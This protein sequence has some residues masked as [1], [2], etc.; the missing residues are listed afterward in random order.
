MTSNRF[1]QKC[2]L[3]P[4]LVL[5]CC[6]MAGLPA[7]QAGPEGAQNKVVTLAYQF[8][9]GRTV[10]YRTTSTQIQNLDAMGQSITTRTVNNMEF[11]AKSKGLKDDNFILGVTMDAF[12]VSVEGPQG[13][14][15]PDP[16]TV[17]G[18]SFDMI[19][20]RLGKVV[21]AAGASSISY[22]MGQSGKR[23]IAAG[24]QTFFPDLPDHPVKIGDAWTS[25]SAVVNRGDISEI[26]I[27]LKNEHKLDGFETAEGYECARIKTTAKGS[28][29]GTIEQSGMTMTLDGTVQ[30]TQTCYFAIKEGIF[31]KGDEKTGSA[32]NITVSAANMSIPIT[33]ESQGEVRLIRK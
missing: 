15:A 7:Q 22:D 19:I 33:S 3:I 12:K 13:N 23:N 2:L 1:V 29:R 6:G 14:T 9:E 10:A 16:S 32:G 30:S 27:A 21:D 5:A 17:I 20:S 26:R 4:M 31:V 24:F 25:E 8:S 28:M 18:K 11:S